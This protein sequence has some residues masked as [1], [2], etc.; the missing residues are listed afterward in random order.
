MRKHATI[1]LYLS[2]RCGF[3]S[4]LIVEWYIYIFKQKQF[5]DVSIY[6][7]CIPKCFPEEI[8]AS[9]IMKTITEPTRFNEPERYFAEENWSHYIGKDL[10]FDEDGK[11]T[12]GSRHTMDGSSLSKRPTKYRQS[13]LWPKDRRPNVAK[14]RC[15]ELCLSVRSRK[16]A[17]S[18]CCNN[19]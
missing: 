4:H 6:S 17:L 13:A 14:Y 1:Q 3:V 5:D 7:V 11:V 15:R 18:S 9:T 2:Y 19:V 8:S 12:E 10:A 16:N